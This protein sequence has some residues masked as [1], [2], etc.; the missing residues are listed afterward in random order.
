MLIFL[1]FLFFGCLFVDATNYV[2]KTVDGGFEK[3]LA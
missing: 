2:V 1:K 3:Y